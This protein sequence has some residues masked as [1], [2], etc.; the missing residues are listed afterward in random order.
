MVTLKKPVAQLLDLDMVWRVVEARLQSPRPLC[1]HWAI[2][3][4]PVL[5]GGGITV[6]VAGSRGLP[7]G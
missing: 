6:M 7:A 5:S 2:Q 4:Q 1:Y 3:I